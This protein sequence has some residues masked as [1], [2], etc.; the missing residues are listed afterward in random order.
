MISYAKGASVLRQIEYRLGKEVFRKG[1]NTY[2]TR[3]AEGNAVLQDFV[4]A[5]E[6]AANTNLDDWAG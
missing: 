3:H 6:A 5:L 4:S 2:L 1:I